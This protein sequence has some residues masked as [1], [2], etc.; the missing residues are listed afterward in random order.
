MPTT[1]TTSTSA[2]AIALD[3]GRRN[4]IRRILAEWVW[5][6]RRRLAV[7]VLLMVGLAAVTGFY[8]RLIKYAFDVLPKGEVSVLYTIAGLIVL[9]TSTRA[10]LLYLTNVASNRIVLR[11]TTAMQKAAIAQSSRWR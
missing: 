7:A 10:L 6:E 5:P 3:A 9:A 2:P 8:P 1:D 11:I 4:L